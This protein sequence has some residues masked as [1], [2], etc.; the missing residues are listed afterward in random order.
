MVLHWDGIEPP[1]GIDV[2]GDVTSHFDWRGT[3]DLFF[4]QRSVRF[5]VGRRSSCRLFAKSSRSSERKLGGTFRG[6]LI[7]NH[8]ISFKLRVRV[9][10]SVGL[11][12]RFVERFRSQKTLGLSVG[13]ALD[14]HL[15]DELGRCCRYSTVFVFTVGVMIKVKQIAARI[16]VN[17]WALALGCSSQASSGVVN[18]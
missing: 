2:V 15:D 13:G 18:L 6:R 16:R 8:G 11:V 4:G 12:L 9:R 1:S 3:S 17:L 14:T 10:L 5:R 7:V